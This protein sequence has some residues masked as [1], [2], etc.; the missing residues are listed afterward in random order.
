MKN[1]AELIAKGS[2]FV[3]AASV[4]GTI[5]GYA[6]R[7]Y[8]A[9]NMSVADFG[10]F[11]AIFAFTSIFI[12]FRDLGLSTTMVKFIS[13]YNA[14][15][16]PGKIKTVFLTG[17]SVQLVIGTLVMA[18]VIMFAPEI[19]Q[20]YFKSPAAATPIVIL[21]AAYIISILFSVQYV[22]QG[23]GR[24]KIFSIIEPM[25]NALTLAFAFLLFSFG[26]NSIAGAAA[27]YLG[28]AAVALS[29]AFIML[30]R[31][32]PIFKFKSAM[33]K[34]ETRSM[35]SFS[36]PVFL[37][38]TAG[39]ALGYADTLILT[40]FRPIEDVALYNV[41][42]PTSQLL[43]V[44]VTSLTTVMLPVASSMWAK[45]ERSALSRITC[46]SI[47][48]LFVSILP[49]ILVLAAFPEV[50]LQMFF[51]GAYV[52]AAGALQLLAITIA[53]QSVFGLASVILVGIGKPKANTAIY[54]SV[55]A[56]NIIAN[57]LLVPSFGVAGAAAAMLLSYGAAALLSLFYLEK[58]MNVRM[59]FV[60]IAKTIAGAGVTLLIFLIVKTA[61]NT[62]LPLEIFASAATGLSFYILYIFSSKTIIKEDVEVFQKADI[63][64]PRL[65]FRLASM[66][67]K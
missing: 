15:K 28:A 60:A 29:I 57:I 10:L 9:K 43:L 65:I 14:K 42:L 20:S 59:P 30:L 2:M 64:L 23:L 55:A 53:F 33:S 35:L 26:M 40:Y 38:A 8:L 48:I 24:V 22:F 51:G 25:R 6:L 18:P 13:E 66:L 62:S 34:N 31:I 56:I 11:Y 52:P 58:N 63:R 7:L 49:F 32:F 50:F 19:A 46:T 3:F 17:A 54:I 5:S 37:A 41:A 16:L 61:L 36:L 45:G 67:A 39:T 1:Y 27:S 21:A 4:V 44:F 12:L 47:K